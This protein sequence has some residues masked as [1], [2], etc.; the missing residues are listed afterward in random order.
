MR[1]YDPIHGIDYL[2]D[3]YAIL[4]ISRDAP[5]DAVIKAYRDKAKQYHPDVLARAG[6]DIKDEA[7]RKLQIIQLAYDTL[8]D[9]EKRAIYDERLAGFPEH[10]ISTSGI[11][12][13]DPTRSRVDIDFLLSGAQWDERDGYLQQ[14]QQ[15][16]GH[17]EMIFKFIEQQY[18]ATSSPSEELRNAYKEA[19]QKKHS[20]LAVLEDIAWQGA[21]VS[22]QKDPKMIVSPDHY[23]EARMEQI[24][25]ASSRIQQGVERR[26]LGITAGEAPKLLGEYGGTSDASE[27]IAIAQKNFAPA[28]EEIR[29][30]AV[31]RK[32]VLEDMVS[33]TQWRYIAERPSQ[34]V[35]VIALAN[36]AIVAEFYARVG[37]DAEIYD[38]K[39][40]FRGQ[41]IDAVPLDGL[42]QYSIASFDIDPELDLFLQAGYVIDKHELAL[43]TLLASSAPTAP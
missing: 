8:S 14:L 22:G 43:K 18:K 19:L 38:V 25:E 20:Y 12:K 4:G 7:V 1:D 35:V 31:Q 17:N 32:E 10:L 36:N 37:E 30:A 41:Q 27:L 5:R 28:A 42:A 3:H 23:L 29:R 40:E 26:L 6:D 16:S 9:G 21:G 15:V 39:R 13:L 2:N 34:D 24:A 11:P 33:L